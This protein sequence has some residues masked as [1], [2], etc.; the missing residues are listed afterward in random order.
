MVNKT[1][2]LYYN[3]LGGMLLNILHEIFTKIQKSFCE[4]LPQFAKH[5]LHVKIMHLIKAAMIIVQLVHCECTP[6]HIHEISE[7]ATEYIPRLAD[8]LVFYQNVIGSVFPERKYKR[9]KENWV[10]VRVDPIHKND[11]KSV[12][13]FKSSDGTPGLSLHRGSVMTWHSHLVTYYV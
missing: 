8:L 7:Q 6:L 2:F 1:L 4:Y 13:Y 3:I 5:W 12:R 10:P 9:G 11:A